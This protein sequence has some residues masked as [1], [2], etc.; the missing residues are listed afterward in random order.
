MRQYHTC[1]NKDCKNERQG[2]LTRDDY[3][4]HTS[5]KGGRTYWCKQCEVDKH[6]KIRAGKGAS[7]HLTW[8]MALANRVLMSKGISI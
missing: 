6:R 2:S 4:R 1:K 8:D 3:H 7:I 5:N